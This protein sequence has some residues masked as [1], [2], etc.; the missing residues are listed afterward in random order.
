MADFDLIV[1]NAAGF[2]FIGIAE[3]RFAALDGDGTA[4]REIDAA[5]MVVL[6]GL[7]DA[8]VHFNEPGRADW[9]GFATGSRAAAAGGITTFFDMPLNSHP[10]TVTAEAF[11]AKAALAAEKSLVDF[12]L[13]GGLVPGHLE[14]LEALRDC[15]AIGLKAFMS[16]SGIAEFPSADLQT[17][18]AG[19]KKAAE[20]GMLVAVHAELDALHAEGGS[21]VREYLASRPVASE[22]AAIV[23]ACEI[24]GETGC[25][26]HIVHVSSAGGVAA[27]VQARAAGVDVTC[28][29]CPHYLFFT[30]EDVERLGA[31]A[32]C[33]PPIRSQAERDEL[34]ACLRA[35][36][37]QTVGTDHSP[38]PPSMKEAAS[39]FDVWGGISGVQ[40]LL[41]I[42]FELKFS[43]TQIAQLTAGNV[44]GRFGIDQQKGGIAVGLDADLT[45]FDPARPETVT[46]DALHYRHQ[47]SPYGGETFRGSVQQTLLRGETV[48]ERGKGFSATRGRLITPQPLV[49]APA[50]VR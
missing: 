35:G 15:G 36:E 27:V 4:A 40:H 45:L 42:L 25:R 10:P 1:R 12:A 5:G 30:E 37:I 43:P 29:T 3:G 49:D 26:L 23:A 9:E 39:F 34:R 21:T 7:I 41:P 17:L 16:G 6:P 8:H 38:A 50:V 11:R 33:A 46:A 18:R 31:V 14:D 2:P 13:W 32:K 28:E 19:M 24:A 22:V 44:A 48:W 20:L 47:Q